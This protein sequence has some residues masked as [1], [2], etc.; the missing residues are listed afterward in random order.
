MAALQCYNMLKLGGQSILD[1]VKPS[2]CPKLVKI[3]NQASKHVQT[4]TPPKLSGTGKK[5]PKETSHPDRHRSPSIQGIV[6]QD[7]T[8][9]QCP[10]EHGRHPATG[11][12]VLTAEV[13]ILDLRHHPRQWAGDPGGKTK[14]QTHMALPLPKRTQKGWKS[15]EANSNSEE[16]HPDLRYLQG[17][18][19][20][21][22]KAV[23]IDLL[24]DNKEK[25]DQ[26]LS[27]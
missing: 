22:S 23:D 24:K 16:L 9:R 10:G 21:K 13:E 4:T 7:L 27:K 12:H 14:R 5:K 6:S 11:R 8:C 20:I 2:A 25:C 1:K 26:H 19:M 18:S 15:R 17:R 3:L